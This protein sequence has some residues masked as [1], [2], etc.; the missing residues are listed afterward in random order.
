[1]SPST[2]QIEVSW[3]LSSNLCSPDYYIIRYSVYQKLACLSPED[4]LTEFEVNTNV[5]QY[6]NL[7]GLEPYS[8]YKISVTAVNGAGQS[9]PAIGYSD[10]TPAPPLRGRNDRMRVAKMSGKG[11]LFVRQSPAREL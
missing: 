4:T 1:M 8:R 3:E 11:V 7:V 9:E 6:N 5:T 10:T 2:T